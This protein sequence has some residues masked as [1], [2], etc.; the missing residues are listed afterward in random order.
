MGGKRQQKAKN[1]NPK[2]KHELLVS[3]APVCRKW[4]KCALLFNY[5]LSFIASAD[6]RTAVTGEAGA[7][8]FDLLH[9][10]PSD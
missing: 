8:A 1:Q 3:S 6:I 5:L 9:K 4:P 10:R 2:H 7:A